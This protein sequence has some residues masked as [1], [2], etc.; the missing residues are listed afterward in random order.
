MIVPTDLA[1]P[2]ELLV[3]ELVTSAF[4]Y[5]YPHGSGEVRADLTS[6]PGPTSIRRDLGAPST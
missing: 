6:A 1:V 3:N 2:F 4:K 5:A